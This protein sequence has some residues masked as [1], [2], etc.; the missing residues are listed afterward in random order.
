[1]NVG[2][3]F[4]FF[5]LYLRQIWFIVRLDLAFMSIVKV[6]WTLGAT[7]IVVFIATAILIW[8]RW[9]NKGKSSL[10]FRFSIRFGWFSFF[11]R[12]LF[13]FLFS[14][15]NAQ[16]AVDD[17][18]NGSLWFVNVYR[19]A[20]VPIK[21][22]HIAHFIAYAHFCFYQKATTMISNHLFC[23]CACGRPKMSCTFDSISI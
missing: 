12:I 22:L 10:W 11:L 6:F 8:Q 13:K 23:V 17:K 1:M 19:F 7:L 9:F 18:K 20:V 21:S 16:S 5:S 2:F 14:I 3:Y 4:H 15:L